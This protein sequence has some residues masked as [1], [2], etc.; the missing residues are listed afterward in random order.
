MAHQLWTSPITGYRRKGTRLSELR[1]LI[2]AGITVHS[3]LEPLQSRPADAPAQEMHRLLRARD[4]DIAGVQIKQDD[5]VIGFVMRESLTSGIVRDHMEPLSAEH[6][7][8]DGTPLPTVLSGLKARQSVFVL[9]GPT[10]TGIATRADL[11]K[12]P[13]RMYLFI[14]VSLLEMHLAFW[15]R[16]EYPDDTWQGYVSSARLDAAKEVRKNRE[17]VGQASDLSDC[18]QM[19]DKRDLVLRR[20]ALCSD[21]GLVP[22]SQ[23]RSHLNEAERLRNLLA[24]GQ[25]N[26][27]EGSSWEDLIALVERLERIVHRSDDLVGERAAVAAQQ[28]LGELWS[29]A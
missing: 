10:V 9:I 26:L 28:G 22:K 11:N 27:V 29:S 12:P 19:G 14:L 17:A 23:A 1:S 3:I 16:A 6:L 7:V 24:H 4:F 21:L 20:G 5:P 13:V 8:S 25:Q 2:D 18:L 15:V